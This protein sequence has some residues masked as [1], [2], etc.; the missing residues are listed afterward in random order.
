MNTMKF[1]A[2]AL[3]LLGLIFIQCKFALWDDSPP[4]QPNSL[5][6]QD[7]IA[8]RAILDANGLNKTKVRD[9]ISLQNS[10]VGSI[11]FNSL[12]LNKI[13]ITN[14]FNTFNYG[15]SLNINNCPIETIEVVDTIIINIAIAMKFTKLKSIPNNISLFQGKLWLYLNN[16]EIK[17][18]PSEIMNCNVFY[19]DVQNNEL[20]SV[21]DTLNKWIIKNSRD[22]YWQTTQRCN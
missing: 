1:P 22:S 21:P 9:V 3:L 8:V 2:I 10:M 18:M 15:F 6:P 11:N 17:Y 14:S 7:S 19:I 4:P 5:M 13:I 16:N 20:C 12:M